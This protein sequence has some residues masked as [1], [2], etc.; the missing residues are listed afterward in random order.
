MRDLLEIRAVQFCVLM[1]EMFGTK[2]MQAIM[3]QAAEQ[4]AMM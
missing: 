4:A 2:S 1:R 3:S